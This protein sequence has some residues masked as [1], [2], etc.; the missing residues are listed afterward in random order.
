MSMNLP[1]VWPEVIW[2]EEWGK[3]LGRSVTGNSF[4]DGGVL[5]SFPLELFVSDEPYVVALMGPASGDTVLGLLI[6]EALAAT[7]EDGAEGPPVGGV[8]LAS[9]RVLQRMG[10]LLDTVLN[11]RDLMVIDA[12]QPLVARLPAKG[13]KTLEFD[14]DDRRRERLITGGRAAMKQWFDRPRPQSEVELEGAAIGAAQSRANRV[15]R[16]LLQP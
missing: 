1:L 4:V 2:R 16:E 13:Y 11:A 9:L 3:Y 8:S 14:M 10:R 12:Y 15:A 7:D 5:S 6:D